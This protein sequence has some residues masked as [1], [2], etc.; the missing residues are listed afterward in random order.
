MC[1]YVFGE[2]LDQR[3]KFILYLYPYISICIY[4]IYLYV[5]IS[6]EENWFIKTFSVGYRR[7]LYVDIEDIMYVCL[8]K[9]REIVMD[10]EPW[11][12]AVHAVAKSPTWLSNWTT[13]N[14]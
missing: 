14:M 7:Y 9:L 5:H 10:R 6:E 13:T 8:C 11:C 2:W 1:V 4:I 3:W 12:A